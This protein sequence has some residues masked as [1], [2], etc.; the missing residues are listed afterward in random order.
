MATRTEA[1]AVVLSRFEIR[2]MPLLT[3]GLPDVILE[4]VVGKS[5]RVAVFRAE[6]VGFLLVDRLA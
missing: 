3:P 4:G 2:F 1:I 5:N 6:S